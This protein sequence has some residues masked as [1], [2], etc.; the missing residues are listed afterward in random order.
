MPF[1]LTG[2][3]FYYDPRPCRSNDHRDITTDFLPVVINS[4]TD[5]RTEIRG[6]CAT[7]CNVA[8][9]RELW[10]VFGNGESRLLVSTSATPFTYSDIRLIYTQSCPTDS[11]EISCQ[12]QPNGYCCIKKSLIETLCQRLN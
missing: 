8:C 10:I 3:T 6:G 7:P 5:Y 2:I 4:L 9:R 1:T 12:G 11:F